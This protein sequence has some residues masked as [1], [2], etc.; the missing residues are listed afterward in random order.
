[1]SKSRSRD[2][3]QFPLTKKI[4]P[5]FK[6]MEIAVGIFH[7][8]SFFFSFRARQPYISE[9]NNEVDLRAVSRITCA[10]YLA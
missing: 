6:G 8:H 10:K 2:E 4:A 9:L 7:G 3:E 1:M 5:V